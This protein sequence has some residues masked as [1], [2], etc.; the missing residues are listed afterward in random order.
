MNK[1]Q[2][3]YS[4]AK[5]D[6]ALGYVGD[7]HS[8]RSYIPLTECGLREVQHYVHSHI[9]ILLFERKAHPYDAAVPRDLHSWQSIVRFG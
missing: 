3:L 2:L 8:H 1:N 7:R 4:G 9:V 6:L 5:Y